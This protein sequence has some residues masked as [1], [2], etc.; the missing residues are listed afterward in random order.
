MELNLQGDSMNLKKAE[1]YYTQVG[2]RNADA[3]KDY[4][5]SEV[6]FK[7]PLGAHKGK[8]AVIEA[9]RNFMNTFKSLI[10]RAKLG[11]GD[12]AMIVYEVDIPNV[13]PTFMGTSLLTFKEGKIVNI[14]LFF[15]G[16]RFT[17]KA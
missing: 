4:L 12:Q 17:K 2:A 14:E 11:A 13:S 16:S 15:D 3:I 9:T 5:D 8:E 7:G 1:E 6:V 10:I